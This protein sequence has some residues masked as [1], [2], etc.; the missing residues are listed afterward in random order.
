MTDQSD[1]EVLAR[2]LFEKYNLPMTPGMEWATDESALAMFRQDAD[3]ILAL[4]FSRQQWQPIESAPKDGTPVLVFHPVGG[5]C[6]AWALGD[7][8]P[9]YCIDGTNVVEA[10]DIHGN[11]LGMRPALTSFVEPP[12]Q[13]MPLPPPPRTTP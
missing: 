8:G 13:W 11:V 1:R 7:S 5:V 6:E 9:W 10:K 4:G 12:T 2:W 3:A